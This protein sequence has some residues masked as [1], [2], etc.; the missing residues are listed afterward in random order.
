M[1]NKVKKEK[2][3]A[4]KEF[5]ECFKIGYYNP[6]WILEFIQEYQFKKKQ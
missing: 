4:R 3:K 5:I 1:R 6:D 2:D